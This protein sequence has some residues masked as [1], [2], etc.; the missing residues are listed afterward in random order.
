MILTLLV[1]LAS[2]EGNA[3]ILCNGSIGGP[4]TDE[5]LYTTTTSDGGYIMVGWTTSFGAGGWDL[6]LVKT[7]ADGAIEWTRTYGG[8]GDEVDCSVEQTADGGYI[9]ASRTNSFGAGGADVYLV[10]TDPS[11][12][13]EWTKT[14]GGAGWEEG[15]SV[16]QTSDGGYILTGWTDSFGAGSQ[17]IYVVRT[18]AVGTV[19]WTRTY[20]GAGSERGH[21]IKRTPDGGYLIAAE[22]NGFG[23]GGWDLLLVQIAADGTPL[24]SKTYGG[25][26]DDFGWDA[27]PT[28]DGGCVFVGYTNSFGAG[29]MDMYLLKLDANGTDQWAKTYGGS[30]DEQGFSVQPTTDGGFILCGETSGYGNGEEDAIAV[31]VDANGVFSWARTFGGEG[32][33]GCQYG[34]QTPDGGYLIS[35]YSE[36]AGPDDWDFTLIKTDALGNSGGCNETSPVLD[37][38]AHTPNIGLFDMLV[39][40]GG[41]MAY[42]GTI[43]G[44]GGSAFSCSE[45]GMEE[46][47]VG[48]LL[49]YPNPTNGSITLQGHSG[50]RIVLTD[51]WGA[52]VAEQM[53]QSATFT[54]DLGSVPQGIYSVAIVRD[55]GG[56]S[57]QQVVKM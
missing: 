50:D 41:T 6:Y 35:G 43:T 57:C 21:K 12:A 14:Y 54:L 29:A 56:V 45:V 7:Q 51:A 49:I 31:R 47:P 37:E 30:L 25:A 44:S 16:L 55:G 5:A 24:W 32:E 15:H 11:G 17:D 1:C 3:Q 36:K 34:M 52:V 23:A 2:Y 8:P 10:K 53:Q 38:Q 22:T 48:Q 27:E 39:G 46:R 13:P 9:I 42:A 19:L 18:D 4:L 28:A 33:D 20:G 40:E 26:G